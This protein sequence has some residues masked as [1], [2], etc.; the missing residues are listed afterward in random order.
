M[1][2]GLA[3]SPALLAVG[4]I[5]GPRIASFVLVGGLIGWTIILPVA[6]LMGGW[7]ADIVDPLMGVKYIWKEQ[8]RYIGVGA[9]L[10]GGLWTIWTLRSNLAAGIKEAVLGIKGGAEE[11]ARK[12]TDTDLNL[13][14]V[15]LLIGAFIIPVFI[16]YAWVSKMYALSGFMAVFA[17]LMAFIASAI[18]GYM[19]GLVGSSNNPISGVTVSVL[20]I[21]SLIL[22]AAGIGTE[23]M[24]VAILI[25]AII[26]CGA[27][28]SGDVLQS[29][30]CGWMVG[31]TPWKQQIAEIIGVSAAA[32]ILA[33]VIQMLDNAF[34]IGSKDLPA[35]Q[36]FLMAG[37]VKGILGGK[38]IWPYVLV[39]AVLAF[40]LILLDLPVLPVA[41][42]IYLPFTL[43]TP[44]FVGGILRHFT[45]K[46]IE[47]R[48]GK[49]EEEEISDWELAIKQTGIK[50][51]EKAIR[52]GLLLTAGFVA[53]EALMGVIIAALYSAHID[54]ALFPIGSEPWWPGLLIWAYIGALLLYIPLRVSLAKK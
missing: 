7:P 41:I 35:P 3:T 47:K 43:S 44:I 20:L 12:R 25:A 33:I 37:I 39:G 14:T 18:A 34:V 38:M 51:Q 54:L 11:A 27:A 24:S 13:K 50:P 21:T 49:A 19:A 5:I 1:Y 52:T 26:C 28:I 48:F 23:G 30:A 22:F 9:M 46:F 31:A 16:V 29:M 53:G 36:A 45:N 32:P 40:V 8:I 10:V 6:V 17:I 4:W 2:G 15:F 42:G